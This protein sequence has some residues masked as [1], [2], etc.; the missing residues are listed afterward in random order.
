MTA[1]TPAPRHHAVQSWPQPGLKWLPMESRRLMTPRKLLRLG[2]SLLAA[3]VAGLLPAGQAQAGEVIAIH[4][5][6][7]DPA[8]R[9]AHDLIRDDAAFARSRA[10]FAA[11]NLP[12]S[13]TFVTRSCEGRGGAW[14]FDF[15]VTICY[16][17]V[18]NLI[19]GAASAQ[20]PAWVSAEG[21]VRGG[22]ADVALHEGA[23]ALFEAFRTPLLGKEEDAADMV[24]TFAILNLFGAEAPAMVRGVA[25]SY[26]VD[27]QVRNFSDLPTLQARAPVSRAYGG[28]HSTALQRM[29]SIVCHALGVRRAGLC[30]P[31]RGQR[32]AALEGQRLRGR[33]QADRPCFRD[34]AR[35]APEPGTAGGR[36]PF[37]RTCAQGRETGALSAASAAP[38]IPDE[39]EAALRG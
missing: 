36:L 34:A 3:C 26:L 32:P 38:T 37:A 11:F 28:A 10:F 18:Q 21:A 19:D 22:I 1:R 2:A 33:I 30:R 8:H 27:A 12:R 29:F 17:Y 5:P 6:P 24:S 20:R 25:Y 7:T 16:E 15:K 4:E 9:A 13:L 31:C 14:Y 39:T 23:H 35:P